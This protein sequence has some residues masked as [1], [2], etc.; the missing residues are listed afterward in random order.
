MVTRNELS[1]NEQKLTTKVAG[2]AALVT[3]LSKTAWTWVPQKN[4]QKRDPAVERELV[5]TFT[6]DADRL[7]LE[8]MD[9]CVMGRPLLLFLPTRAN[10]FPIHFPQT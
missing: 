4:P 10:I 8:S 6:I 1:S 3:A 2:Y 5:I 9:L 7:C